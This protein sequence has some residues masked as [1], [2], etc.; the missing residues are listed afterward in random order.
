[1][2]STPAPA[3][4]P[5]RPHQRWI[6]ITARVLIVAFVLWLGFVG[7]I[8]RAMHRPPEAFARVMSYLPWEAFLILPF[9]TLWSRARAGNLHPGDAA[10]DFT[11]AKLD[12]SGTVRLSELGHSQP[13]VV[14][15]GSYT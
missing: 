11:L 13:V 6:K 5:N 9:E 3:S 1:M 7:F 8:W 4:A 12:K 15:F 2:S 14:I 10:P